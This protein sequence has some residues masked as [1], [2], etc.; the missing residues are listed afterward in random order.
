LAIPLVAIVVGMEI[1]INNQKEIVAEA[2]TIQSVADAKLGDK[3][4]G[5]A[6]ALNNQ[7]VAKPD[8]SSTQLKNN[9]NILII[10]ATQGG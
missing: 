9:D 6:I 10:K 3:Q 4:K 1:I 5:V 8:W 2:S 7:V